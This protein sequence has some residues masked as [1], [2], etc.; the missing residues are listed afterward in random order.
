MEGQR[1]SLGW[2]LSIVY[3]SGSLSTPLNETFSLCVRGARCVEWSYVTHLPAVVSVWND[4]SLPCSPPTCLATGNIEY[5]CP[6]TNECEI[7]KRRRKS[8]QACRFMKCLTVGMLREG[9]GKGLLLLF[10]CYL[11]Y[12]WHFQIISPLF[13]SFLLIELRLKRPTA[14]S[15]RCA[16]FRLSAADFKSDLLVCRWLRGDT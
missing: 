6:A 10:L 8:C 16:E 4:T 2:V 1:S 5:S 15:G 12:M 3:V 14:S 11:C 13:I 7:T 9:K